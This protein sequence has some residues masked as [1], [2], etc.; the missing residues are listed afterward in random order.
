MH[1]NS[2][3]TIIITSISIILI[4]ILIIHLH[5]SC[6]IIIVIISLSTVLLPC[7]HILHGIVCDVHVLHSG[8]SSYLPHHHALSAVMMMPL[9]DP[10]PIA[11]ALKQRLNAHSLKLRNASY[12][13]ERYDC[14][15]HYDQVC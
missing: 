14:A 2:I 3:I 8:R 11:Q 9:V 15:I 7:A 4:I 6:V 13:A 5:A 12:S 1:I 10:P